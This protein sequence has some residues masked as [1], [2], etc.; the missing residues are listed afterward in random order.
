MTE[1][2]EN[3]FPN[4][5]DVADRTDATVEDVA[6]DE[7]REIQ[8]VESLCMRCHDNGI[9]RF[10]LTTIPYFKEIV[11]SSF[12]C[13]HCGYRDTEVQPAGEVQREFDDKPSLRR[14]L[15]RSQGLLV[16]RAHALAGRS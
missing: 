9:T 6:D 12:H 8:E 15:T 7:T 13:D 11:V 4:L 5:S 10:L 2:K 1:K 3:F 16:H 14:K